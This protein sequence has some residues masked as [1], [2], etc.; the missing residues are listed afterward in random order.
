MGFAQARAAFGDLLG[1]DGVRGP[2]E[3]QAAWGACTT[4]AARRLAGAVRPTNA[5]SIPEIVRIARAHGIALYPISTGH[6]WGYGT[7]LPVRDDAVIVD[8]SRLTRIDLDR[9]MGVVTVEPGVTQGMLAEFLARGGHPFLTPVHGGGPTC[10]ILGNAL[11]RGYGITPHTDHFGAVLA[12]EAVL[13]DG[14]AYRSPLS[15]CREP[16]EGRPS[17]GGS[18]P[19]WTGCLR[20]AVLASLPA[21]RLRLRGRRSAFARCCSA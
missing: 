12:L 7:A 8:L 10:S 15:S 5:D 11:E 6:N 9:E 17:S 16:G 3:A 20:R 4:G 18:D 13:A 1:P 21:S 14:S 19:S 2:D